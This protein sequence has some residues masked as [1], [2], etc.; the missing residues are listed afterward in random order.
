MLQ[1]QL[2]AVAG[3]NGE[4]EAALTGQTLDIRAGYC[5]SC[6]TKLDI[7]DD[8]A[9]PWVLDNCGAVSDPKTRCSEHLGTDQHCSRGVTGA[10]ESPSV[11]ANITECLVRNQ[12][13]RSS[14][15]SAAFATRP[16]L[17]G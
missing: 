4:L 6:G 13:T 11:S 8:L 3:H 14:I 10:F 15:W 17:R 12:V 2:K 9:S 1:S 16:I 7:N 5:N